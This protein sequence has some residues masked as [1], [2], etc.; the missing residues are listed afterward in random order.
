M[1]TLRLFLNKLYS[2]TQ[3]QETFGVINLALVNGEPKVMS[4]KEMLQHYIDFQAEVIRRRTEF[5]LR[6]AK[7]RG[8]CWKG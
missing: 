5:D 2:Y 4:L 1:R 7:E 3:M 6:K 8:M